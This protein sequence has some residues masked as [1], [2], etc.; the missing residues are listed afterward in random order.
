MTSADQRS[1]KQPQAPQKSDAA[2][3]VRLVR[4]A[5]LL[6]GEREVVIQHANEFYRLRVTKSGKL[7]LHK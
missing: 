5:D 7:I 4:S 2:L 6:Q 3:P 1:D